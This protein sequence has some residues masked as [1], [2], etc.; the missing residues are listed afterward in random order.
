MN[1]NTAQFGNA[2]RARIASACAAVLARSGMHQLSTGCHADWSVAVKFGGHRLPRVAASR[3]GVGRLRPEANYR[4]GTASAAARL[5][6]DRLGWPGIVGLAA[7]AVIGLAGLRILQ[8]A[9][10]A[11]FVAVPV[12][13]VAVVVLPAPVEGRDDPGGARPGLPG[14]ADAA[15]AW[16][17]APGGA[18]DLVRVGLVTGQA[19]VDSPPGPRT[20]PMLSAPGSAGSATSRRAG[21]CWSWS[22]PTPSPTRS[23][24]CRSPGRW[25]WP[26]C[27]WAGARTGRRGGC[28]CWRRMC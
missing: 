7:A 21:C 18:V 1:L 23:R 15:G 27:R 17:G 5:A 10:F 25:T 13:P 28:G 24:R 9:W 3:A 11:R 6:W 16:P 26:G 4:R 12:P 2:S 19:P 8:P 20:W 14:P 22:A